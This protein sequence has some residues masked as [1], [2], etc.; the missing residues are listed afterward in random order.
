MQDAIFIGG[1]KR[2]GF[3]SAL[4]KSQTI[5]SS[6]LREPVSR[7]VSLYHYDKKTGSDFGLSREATL[8][9]VIK[10]SEPFRQKIEQAQN[11]YISG[12]AIFE[13]TISVLKSHN[14][15]V[16]VQDD[17]DSYKSYIQNALDLPI[18]QRVSA[19]VAESMPASSL[20][21]ET[22]SNIIS[23]CSEDIKLYDYIRSRPNMVYSNVSGEAWHSLRIAMD[24]H[25]NHDLTDV[26]SGALYM[27][28]S[29]GAVNAGSHFEVPV[30]FFNS[31]AGEWDNIGSRLKLSYHWRDEANRMIEYEGIR[32]PIDTQVVPP[33]S[34]TPAVL[35]VRAPATPGMYFLELTML[36]EGVTWFDDEGD[37][38]T[39]RVLVLVLD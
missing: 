15:V 38:N 12:K 32:S 19:N 5:F 3:Y 13:E 6:V 27:T 17:I 39:C 26:F 4:D 35:T 22:L 14:F 36:K 29:T 2:F 30:A 1:H 37:F 8:D 25:I 34:W 11:K 23:L 18:N 16:G 20:N 7:I 24:K 31:S 33:H 28:G 9:D 10:F 21:E